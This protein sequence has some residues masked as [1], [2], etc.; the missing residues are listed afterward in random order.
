M[1]WSFAISAYIELYVYF[2][3][4][5]VINVLLI[6]LYKNMSIKFL[7]A[8]LWNVLDYCIKAGEIC[9]EDI[10][11]FSVFFDMNW[12]LIER[13]FLCLLKQKTARCVQ[14]LC[15]TKNYIT[16]WLLVMIFIKVKILIFLIKSYF[17]NK[18]LKVALSLTVGTLQAATLI[19][20]PVNGFNLTPALLDLMPK[21]M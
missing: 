6:G 11:I 13:E 16:I 14:F 17:F 19:F 21:F 10:N 15:A 5:L 12:K 18:F 1:G 2:R 3:L 20:S 8:Y 9:Q 4:H 7:T